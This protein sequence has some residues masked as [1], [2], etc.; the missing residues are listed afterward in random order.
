MVWPVALFAT[1]VAVEDK[2]EVCMSR[3]ASEFCDG[4]VTEQRVDQTRSALVSFPNRHA[5][6]PSI[7][8]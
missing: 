3:V 5:T 1:E 2:S 6:I 4:G 8:C 7:L